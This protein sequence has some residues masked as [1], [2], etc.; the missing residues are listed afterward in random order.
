MTSFTYVGPAN[1]T[2]YGV[3]SSNYLNQLYS[4]EP[5][6][7]FLPIGDV[8][9]SCELVPDVIEKA[10]KNIDYEDP[11]F[12][13]WHLFD[14]KEKT[15]PFKGQ[16]VGLTTFE[17]E[18]L[19]SK[20]LE[21]L[22][23]LD[24]VCSATQ[25]GADVLSKYTDKKVEVIPHAFK[26]DDKVR[27]GQHKLQDIVN[28]WG[29]ALTP[30]HIAE[31]ALILSMAGKFESRK[32][33]PE[34]IEACIRYSQEADRQT[35]LVAFCHNPFIPGGFPYSYINGK[36]MYP[37]YTES[38]IKVFTLGKF[39]L[40]VMPTTKSRQELHSALSKAHFFINP[41]KGEGWNLPLF[42]MMSFG[43]PSI[44]TNVTGHTEY[45]T[46]DN[47]VVV[48]PEGLTVANDGMF[49]KGT[50]EWYNVTSDSVFKA[51]VK[52]TSLD[53]KQLD[54]ITNAA[55]DS[56]GKFTWQKSARK[57]KSLMKKN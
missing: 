17:V 19:N 56:T 53:K 24:V 1:T 15:A 52:A 45:T 26:P 11:V 28:I 27:L 29:K 14:L 6:V 9:P 54:S 30:F 21:S 42:E 46:K 2:G 57:I 35:V 49:F 32:A 55:I 5:D 51:I 4:L 37:S 3:A 7:R 36:F 22:A 47:I 43:M 20:E 33:Y 13:F 39:S 18:T 48:E 16:K 40:V 44:A 34:T 25:W 41:S 10:G 8:S 38:G 12:S 31:D 23:A 50:S